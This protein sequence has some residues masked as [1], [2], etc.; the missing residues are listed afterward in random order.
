MRITNRANLPTPFV[1]MAEDKY[2]I[3]PKRYSVTT[4]LKPVREIL[5]NRRHN[6]EIEQDCSDMI[7]LLFGK[8]VHSI[9]EKYSSGV[10]EFT[11]EKLTVELENG[12]TVSGVVDLY[13]IEK[14]EVVDYKTASTWKV[15]Y[16]DYEDWRK[17]GLAYAW[18][19]RKNGF[20]CEKVVFYA[21]LKD[22][23][24]T[25]AKVDRE[26][27]QSP[28]VKVEFDVADID[29]ID[30]FI[31]D[32]IDEIILYEDKPDS[33]LPLCSLE[34]RWNDGDKYAVM[35]KGRKTA[36]R[37]LDTFAEAE[38]WRVKNGGDFIELRKGVDKKCMD[39][40]LCCTKCSYYKSLQG[41]ENE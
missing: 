27:P 10:S 28:V 4:L 6:E 35:K 21:I 8:A 36:M 32:K 5:L 23:S 7:W 15:I 38:D 41:G 22:W 20:E 17:Q 31:R 25:K 30:K 24:K 13:D 29:E 11:E 18:L 40:C 39:Y 19:L 37:V 2:T 1:R 9:L 26:Y 12:Y 3:T 34:D 14:K 16:K 33:A